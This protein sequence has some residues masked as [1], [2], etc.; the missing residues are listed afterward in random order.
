MAKKDDPLPIPGWLIG[1][2]AIVIAAVAVLNGRKPSEK[3]SKA[4]QTTVDT[5]ELP[6]TSLNELPPLPSISVPVEWRDYVPP[7]IGVKALLPDMPNKNPATE[8]Q[9]AAVARLGLDVENL[10]YGQANAV[11]S[12]RDYAETLIDR[13]ARIEPATSRMLLIRWLVEDAKRI[14]YVMDWSWRTR[15]HDVR[16][17]PRD[18]FRAEAEIY[19]A[20]T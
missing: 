18:A 10:T 8:A 13:T 16:R 6:K 4:R 1:V 9:A 11:L 15:N 7:K 14:E 5:D 17:I 2:G 19:L 3:A 12:A 20:S